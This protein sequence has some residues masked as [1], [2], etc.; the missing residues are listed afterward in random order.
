M[1]LESILHR[2]RWVVAGGLALV[3]A[4]AWGALLSGAGTGMTPQ[5]MT[6]MPRDM[7]MEPVQWTP[8]YAALMFFMWWIMMTAMMLPSAAPVLLLAAALNRS[9]EPGLR[10]YG[11][12]GF[13]A[14]GYLVAWMLFSLAAAAAQ[15]GLTQSGVLSGMM[16]ATDGRLAGALLI[17]AG[18]W[19]LT[20]IK[21]ACL[22]QCRSPLMFLV[23]RRRKGNLGGL[24]MGME[25]GAYCLGCCWLL[26]ALLFVGGVM[27]LY[28]IVGLAV[29]VLAEKLLPAGQRIGRWAGAALVLWGVLLLGGIA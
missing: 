28:W 5:D 22:R 24:A 23:Q 26:M 6:A 25:H 18:L 1:S 7:E 9:V 12:T 16:H 14:A 11:T 17:A 15:W 13:F 27:N 19:Q 10:P 8:G 2:D 21:Q 3:I 29:Y 4:I 20:P